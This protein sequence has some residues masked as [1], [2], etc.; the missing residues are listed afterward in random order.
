MTLVLRL[1]LLSVL[2]A[3]LSVSLVVADPNQQDVTFVVGSPSLE[4]TPDN[5]SVQ[6]M[7]AAAACSSSSSTYSHEAASDRAMSLFSFR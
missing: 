1:S 5:K 3:L 4:V 2:V 7:P 6:R